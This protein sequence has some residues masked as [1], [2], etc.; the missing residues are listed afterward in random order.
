ML[1]GIDR[2]TKNTKLRTPLKNLR[3]ALLAHPASMTSDFHHS[4]DALMTCNDIHVTAAFGPQH[5]MRGDKQDNMIE[6]EDYIDPVHRIPVYS[7]YGRVRR[8]TAEMLD[9]F[10]VILVDLQDVG[11]RIYTFLT[12][13]FYIL[14]DCAKAGKAVWVLDRPNPAGR[15]VEGMTLREGWQSF[16]GAARIPMRHG[17]TLGEASRWYSSRRKLDIDLNVIEMEGYHPDA[18][19]GFGWPSGSLSWVNPSPNAATP[20]MPRCYPGTVLIE[21]THLSEGRGTTRPLETLGAP[22]LNMRAILSRMEKIAPSWLQGCRIRSCHFEPTFH[23]HAG[24]M[25]NGFQIHVDDPSYSHEQFKPYRLVALWL[26]A[27]RLEHPEYELWRSFAYEYET[28][29]LAIDLIN[30]GPEL[31]HWVEDTKA[32]AESFDSILQQ[33]EQDWA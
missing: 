13:L 23:K 11:C 15:P 10:D 16:V 17:L 19:P 27:I 30:G 25:C 4:V 5:G 21:G 32:S 3:V 2:L 1:L 18:A 22:Q 14:E 26:K 7:L 8:P 12:T 31:R 9:R 6:S 24:K 29:R 28:E 33:D 20:W